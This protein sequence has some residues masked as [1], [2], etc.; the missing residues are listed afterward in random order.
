M[1]LRTILI[2]V[3]L[4][5]LPAS[6]Q[7]QQYENINK[8]DNNGKKQGHWIKNYPNGHI[9][10]D[11]YFKD[12]QPTGIFKR[13]FE[14]DT[15]RSILV[16][17]SDGKVAEAEIYHPNGYIAT[18]GKFVNQMKEGKWSFYS[19][20]IRGSLVCEEE[21]LNNLKNGPS[22]KYYH[23]KRPAEKL[24]YSKDIRTGEW[25]QYFPNGNVC[26]KANYIS[27]KLQGKFEVFFANGK[28]EYVGQ[29]KDDARDGLWNIYNIDGSLKYSI[30]YV[31][32]TAK[33]PDLYRKESDYL[34][35]LEKN[36]GKISDPEK[37]G[38]IWE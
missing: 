32:G 26:L 34:D 14:N 24:N 21:Y 6:L 7:A 13:F 25:I 1:N 31:A 8:T 3:L 36:K 27:G 18:K 4:V 23:D 16:F 5:I 12:G 35:S 19:A 9:R 15:L 10:Y 38:T 22:F 37:T 33:N 28:P 29:Y 11:G 2:F 30:E 20:T 17:S